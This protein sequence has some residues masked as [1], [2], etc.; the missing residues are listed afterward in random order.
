M[1]L[2][3]VEAHLHTLRARPCH[4]PH[5]YLFPALETVTIQEVEWFYTPEWEDS[6]DDETPLDVGPLVKVTTLQ[7]LCVEGH[8][9]TDL[10]VAHLK[11]LTQL[12]AL[13][14]MDFLPAGVPGICALPPNL[15]T[16]HLNAGYIYKEPVVEIR[17]TL[18]AYKGRLSSLILAGVFM[19]E[20]QQ[21]LGTLSGLECLQHL[22][23]LDFN[24]H[25]GS[26]LSSRVCLSKLEVLDVDVSDWP[27]GSWPNWDMSQ[28]PKLSMLHLTFSAGIAH[29]PPQPID[30]LGLT[31]VR[32]PHLQITID[33]LETARRAVADFSGWA[34]KQ[35]AITVSGYRA[36]DWRQYR[37]VRDLLGSLAG[38]LPWSQVT[39]N[40][41]QLRWV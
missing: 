9:Q 7:S 25:S 26:S 39:V 23:H 33:N 13:D 3:V 27:A 32:V 12:K 2:K 31:G 30:L 14:M 29:S 16:L 36:V 35:A 8:G 19:D 20:F 11:N 40:K 1:L 24:L 37:S 17:P 38:E 15:Q 22:S 28:C 5:L 4:V 41:E 18:E 21:D 10:A 6:L 34:L